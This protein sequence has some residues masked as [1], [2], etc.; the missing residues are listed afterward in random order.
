MSTSNQIQPADGEF[1][2]DA[3]PYER[4]AWRAQQRFPWKLCASH[5]RFIYQNP[6][7]GEDGLH[8]RLDGLS[9]RIPA[10]VMAGS[11]LN[12]INTIHLSGFIPKR[13]LRA[14]REITEEQ[15]WL[16]SIP[17]EEVER[18]RQVM[19]AGSRTLPLPVFLKLLRPIGWPDEEYQRLL[20]DY[21]EEI[22]F[23]QSLL[24]QDTRTRAEM[25]TRD[26]EM[27]AAARNPSAALGAAI[28]EGVAAA[29][30]KMNLKT[31]KL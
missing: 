3:Q 22:A 14:G 11:L 13:M 12:T 25:Q 17:R 5:L 2:G 8:W 1:F 24:D 30:A 26:G 10:G 19:G 27:I 18:R 23:E 6:E 7:P 15:S 4:D 20:A 9:P 28:A 16:E 31:A 29:L 21:A